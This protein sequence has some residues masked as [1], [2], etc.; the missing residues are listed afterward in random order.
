[1]TS[2]L[3]P[4]TAALASF[5]AR[6]A[7]ERDGSET[8]TQSP[9]ASRLWGQPPANRRD[10]QASATVGDGQFALQV[11]YSPPHVVFCWQEG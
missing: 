10:Q 1:V 5:P 2:K 7:E 8:A 6:M 3:I 4:H 9:E 11:K